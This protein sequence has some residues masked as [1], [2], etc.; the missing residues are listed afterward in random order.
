MDDDWITDDELGTATTDASG[1][2]CIYYRS[3]DFKKTFLSPV[4]N[5]ETPLLP[6]GNGPDIY[7]KFAFNGNDLPGEPSSRA[8]QADRENVGNCL[9]VQL[10]VPLG[11]GGTNPQEPIASAWTGIGTAFTIPL[12][13]NLNDFDD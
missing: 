9:C 8:R 4:V 5:V 1:R 12:G 3:K 6:W 7:F 10:C 11:G 2:F 13:A